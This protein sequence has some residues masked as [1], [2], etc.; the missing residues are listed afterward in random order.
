MMVYFFKRQL[1]ITI[2]IGIVNIVAP[3][4]HGQKI[5]KV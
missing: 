3:I 1:H 5:D 2:V 4:M